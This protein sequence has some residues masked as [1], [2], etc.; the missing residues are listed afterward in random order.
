[1]IRVTTNDHDRLA[2]LIAA[3]PP[4]PVGWVKAAQELPRVRRALDDLIARSEADAELRA[5]ILAD[6]ESALAESGI[7]PTPRIL[8]E[9][10]ARMRGGRD[11]G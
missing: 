8:D 5:R 6:L 11:G 4:T 9:V 7:D 2:R 3:L 10:R 1:M